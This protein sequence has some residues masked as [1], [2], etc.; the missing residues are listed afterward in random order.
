[1]NAIALN[2]TA[3]NLSRVIGPAIAGTLIAT[4]G[5]AVCFFLNAASFLAVLIGLFLIKPDPALRSGGQSRAGLR[6][7]IAHVFGSPWPK[8]LVTLTAALNTFGSSFIAILPVYARDVLRSGAGGYG[9]LMSFFGLGAAASAISI[10]AVGHRFRRERTAVY[11]GICMAVSLLVLSLVHQLGLALVVLLCAGL[12]LASS[13]IM[14]NTLLQTE[15]P[16]H[17]R[18]QVM[19]FYSFIVVGMAPFGSL[20]A[21]WIAE[22]QGTSVALQLGGGICLVVASAIAWR[23]LRRKPVV[24]TPAGQEEIS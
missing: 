23:M 21:G 4:L 8:A 22:H 24:P 9:A 17:L 12:C 7:G 13:A 2:S 18:G 3:F 6:E 14:T 16:D 1:M 15:A 5:S 20:Q 11:A 10:A 19:G